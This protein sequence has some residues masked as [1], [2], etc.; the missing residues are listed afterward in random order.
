MK[1]QQ[2]QDRG[3]GQP[4]PARP[5]RLRGVVSS[6]RLD[7]GFGFIGVPGGP[8]VFF[9]MS[10]LAGDLT[11]DDQLV[12]RRV[13]FILVSTPQGPRARVVRPDESHE[14]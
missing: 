6:V 11:F 14:D 2:Q 3:P 8:D 7:R 10:D 4:Q 9:H 1:S 12:R 5:Q 13:Q